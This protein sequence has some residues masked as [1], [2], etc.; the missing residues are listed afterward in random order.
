MAGNVANMVAEGGDARE[1]QV[2]RADTSAAHSTGHKAHDPNVSFEE[3]LYWAELSRNDERYED[4][5]HDYTLFGKVL[6]KARR[7][8]VSTSAGA[9]GNQSAAPRNN[10]HLE[11][12]ALDEKAGSESSPQTR[13][14]ITDDEYVNASRAVR[15]ATWGAVFYLITTDIL[16]PFSVPW[17]LAAVS[18]SFRY[19]LRSLSKSFR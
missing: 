3:Y 19:T 9:G 8:I 7:P 17:A 14:V 10:G 12:E 4:P 6:K 1:E 18:G 5:N 13:F 11:K 2:A 16:G 15:N